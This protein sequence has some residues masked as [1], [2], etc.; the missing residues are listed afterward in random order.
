M[1]GSEEIDPTIPNEGREVRHPSKPVAFQEERRTLIT[2]PGD[3]CGA[4]VLIIDG[5]GYCRVHQMEVTVSDV[6][7]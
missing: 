1:T 3:E 2:C 6:V 4:Q 5:K 7:S